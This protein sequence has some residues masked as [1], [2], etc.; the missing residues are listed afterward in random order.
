MSIINIT[1]QNYQKEIMESKKTILLD[2]WAEWCGPCKIITP[3]IDEIANEN[4]DLKVC[5]INV[6]EQP[7]LANRF[8]V[9]SIP[10]LFVM[11][12]GEII[13]QSVGAKPKEDILKML[14]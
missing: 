12:E 2:F 5:K 4:P 11:K 1:N 10:S 3:V 9:R 7:E 6:D 14:Q 13:T 8:H